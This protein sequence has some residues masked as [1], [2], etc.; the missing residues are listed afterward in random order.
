MQLHIQKL[1]AEGNIVAAR[2]LESGTFKAPAFG[3]EPTQR[4]YEIVAMEWFEIEGGKIKRR[5]GARDSGSQARQ[6]GVS[7]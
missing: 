4:S 7:F 2:Y 6:P 5:R 1:L 3:K